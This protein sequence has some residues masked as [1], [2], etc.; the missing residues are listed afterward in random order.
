MAVFVAGSLR[1]SRF[2]RT[3]A[4]QGPF[5]TRAAG[6]GVRVGLIVP[7]LLALGRGSVATASVAFGSAQAPCK[8]CTPASGRS[9]LVR[10]IETPTAPTP[11]TAQ[12]S[13]AAI[14]VIPRALFWLLLWM[15]WSRGGIASSTL[16]RSRSAASR[17]RWSISVKSVTR[18]H[19]LSAHGH[20]LPGDSLVSGRRVY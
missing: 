7:L 9:A 5:T 10:V 13:T 3:T 14:T 16:A 19:S 2:P 4:V 8:A 17:A 20:L 12:T 11:T 15:A 6:R 1:V 18:F